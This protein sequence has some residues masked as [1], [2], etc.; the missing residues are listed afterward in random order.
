[1]THFKSTEESLWE[2]GGKQE[3]KFK[4]YCFHRLSYWCSTNQ[5]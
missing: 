1:M 5:M 4:E 3:Q 2:Y